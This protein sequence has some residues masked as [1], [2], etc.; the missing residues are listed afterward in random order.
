MLAAVGVPKAATNFTAC[1]AS[2][3]SF[4]WN[5]LPHISARTR[6]RLQTSMPTPNAKD[7]KS[8]SGAL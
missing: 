7:P 8:T 3:F 4:M 6:P 1:L 2:S 5:S